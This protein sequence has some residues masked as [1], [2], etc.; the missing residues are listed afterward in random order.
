MKRLR[1]RLTL[2]FAILA[3]FLGIAM[4]IWGPGLVID[5]LDPRNR[6]GMQD[7]MIWF[8]QGY[9]NADGDFV[10]HG[11]VRWYYTDGG[12]SREESYRNGV[13][14][15]M[16]RWWDPQR[17][18]RSEATYADGQLHGVEKFWWPRTIRHTT[19]THGRR[20]GRYWETTYEGALVREVELLNDLPSSP[21]VRYHPTGV[22][23]ATATWDAEGHCT[24]EYHQTQEPG[25]YVVPWRL[26]D[27]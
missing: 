18:L 7:G 22:K 27:R 26:I 19:W 24:I 9:T 8:K 6:R 25:V 16:W 20:T 23:Y 21:L 10:P 3:M 1:N 15:G 4:A 17:D 12:L 11:R 2:L 5:M 13:E 14:D